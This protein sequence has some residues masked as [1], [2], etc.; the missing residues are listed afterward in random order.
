MKIL[1]RDELLLKKRNVSSFW[2]TRTNNKYHDNFN[3]Q[4]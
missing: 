1:R 2:K 4:Y 3:K